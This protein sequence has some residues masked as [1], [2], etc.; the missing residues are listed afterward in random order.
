MNGMTENE[1]TMCD[2]ISL[3][4]IRIKQLED[5]SMRLFDMVHEGE[6]INNKCEANELYEIIK[7]EV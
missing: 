3:Q 2:I 5:A 4:A 1:K 7:P 6:N